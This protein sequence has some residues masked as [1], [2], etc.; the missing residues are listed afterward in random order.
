MVTSTLGLLCDRH[1]HHLSPGRSSPQTETLPPLSPGF[2]ALPYHPTSVSV[3]LTAPGT[4]TSG[5]SQEHP[6]VTGHSA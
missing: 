2:P 4:P 5:L 6:F 3:G 1:P